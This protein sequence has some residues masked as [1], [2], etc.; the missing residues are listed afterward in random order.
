MIRRA[1]DRDAS[2]IAEISVFSKRMNYREIF[3]DDMV[4]FGEIQV[5]PL[6][7][8]YI[9]HPE[10]LKNFYVYEDDFVKGFIHIQET[11][12]LELYVDTFFLD[13]G[14]GGKLLDFAVSRNCNSLWVLEKNTKAQRFYLR[15]GFTPSGVRQLE[16]G[17]E[18]FI[19]EMIR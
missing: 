5:Y 19:I 2:R 14:I 6:A 17:T 1:I 13:Q 9:E 10:I 4:S 18:Q 8:E 11:Q 16:E 7:K 15:H 12:V 3:R